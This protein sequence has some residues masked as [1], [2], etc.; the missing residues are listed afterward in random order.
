MEKVLFVDGNSLFHRAWHAY[1]KSGLRDGKG[2]LWGVYGFVTLLLGILEKLKPTHLLIGFDDPS[3]KSFRKELDPGYKAQRSDKGDEFRGQAERL[4]SFLGDLGVSILIYEGMEADDIAGSV[5]KRCEELGYKLAIATSDRDAL[6]L[7]SDNVFIYQLR[8]GLDKAVMYDKAR[9]LEEYGVDPESYVAFAAMRG[10]T[11]D[12]LPGVY[13]VGPKGAASI[14]SKYNIYDLLKL[15]EN[16]E[17]TEPKW[18]LES[19]NRE[20]ILH[21]IKMMSA[22]KTLPITVEAGK[23][24]IEYNASKES[25]V[26]G[27]NLPSLEGRIKSAFFGLV[28]DN[29]K[30]VKSIDKIIN[31]EIV[32]VN[33]VSIDKSLFD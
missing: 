20:I 33:Y 13:G 7:V 16:G 5:A 18:V 8:N 30:N 31:D 22:V 14:L 2:G 21:N 28:E 12:N 15:A 17:I 19:K 23:L 1:E 4:R 11:S 3:G 6:S 9:V 26:K 27:E 10:D 25:R 32:F 24:P 29:V